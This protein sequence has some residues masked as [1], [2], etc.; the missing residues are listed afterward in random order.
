[1]QS[2]QRELASCWL[3]V[4]RCD[5][6][7]QKPA[8]RILTFCWTTDNFNSSFEA[9]SWNFDHLGRRSSGSN[10]SKLITLNASILQ[11]I[12]GTVGLKDIAYV[13][14]VKSK[15]D[16]TRIKLWNWQCCPALHRMFAHSTHNNSRD[17]IRKIYQALNPLFQALVKTSRW[18]HNTKL[19]WLSSSIYCKASMLEWQLYR[20]SLKSNFCMC[21]V[22]RILWKCYRIWNYS[23]PNAHRTSNYAIAVRIY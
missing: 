4:S 15:S 22:I 2:V 1:M 19:S 13:V 3:L 14:Q 6:F 10:K 20:Y 11:I 16:Q 8:S 23:S 21:V 7:G 12:F 5:C 17:K 18:T 9:I